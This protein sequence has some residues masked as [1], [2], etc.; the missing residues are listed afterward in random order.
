MKPLSERL[1]Q[2]AVSYDD[3]SCNELKCANCFANRGCI[4][5]HYI[6]NRNMEKS[7]FPQVQQGLVREKDLPSALCY[8]V[9]V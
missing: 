1:Q 8:N 2:Q 7:E 5:D 9:A 3:E 6:A 4:Y